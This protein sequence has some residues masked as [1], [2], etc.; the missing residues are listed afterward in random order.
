[1]KSHYVSLL[2][3]FVITQSPECFSQST[4]NNAVPHI[5]RQTNLKEFSVYTEEDLSPFLIP[6]KLAKDQNYTMG[7]GFSWSYNCMGGVKWLRKATTHLVSTIFHNPGFNREKDDTITSFYLSNS[8]SSIS[9]AAFT[10]DS[11]E[12][13]DI[14]YND[15][16]YSF[17]LS[18]SS[19]Q[20]YIEKSFLKAY[21][22]RLSLGAYGLHVGK[23]IQ[24]GIHVLSNKNDTKDPHTPRG[25]NHQISNYFE[26]TF[27]YEYRVDRLITSD[28]IKKRCCR[29]SSELS[30]AYEILFGY[31]TG[32]T[33]ELS[34]RLGW[35]DPRNWLSKFNSLSNVN[36]D[37]VDHNRAYVNAYKKPW[38]LF[39]YYSIKPNIILYNEGLSGGIV[40]SD[41][42]LQPIVEANPFI[43]EASVGVGSTIPL[44]CD[45]YL[46]VGWAPFSMRTPEM[47]GNKIRR[48]HS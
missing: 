21:T 37:V 39:F 45:R 41:Y 8:I 48:A 29:S 27:L 25:W 6:G 7:I 13:S 9:G 47:W 15:R 32:A 22:Y 18:F 44:R 12:K 23:A 28:A 34:G 38:E 14:S 31:Y 42:R 36:K 11:L 40:R 35:L 1:M 2:I 20:T 46:N 5:E 19:A 10:P 24:A 26:P 16:P 3:T 33:F 43:I 30:Y 17:L 4:C